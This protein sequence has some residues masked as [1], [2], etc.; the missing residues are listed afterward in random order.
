MLSDIAQVQK[1]SVPFGLEADGLSIPNLEGSSAAG[2]L[3]PQTN[4]RYETTL[5]G[6]HV[7]Q[8]KIVAD[9]RLAYHKLS[10]RKAHVKEM[11]RLDAR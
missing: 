4:I 2:R 3:F 5:F 10:A 9:K 11:P 7:S 1:E 8:T 6:V